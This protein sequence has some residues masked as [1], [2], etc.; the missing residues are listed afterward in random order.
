MEQQLVEYRFEEKPGAVTRSAA[1]V[2]KRA[3]EMPKNLEDC[4]GFAGRNAS[5]KKNRKHWGVQGA[6]QSQ[7]LKDLR[8][9]AG[10]T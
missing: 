1:S 2:D 9:A 7:Y 5:V 10:E 6:D 3:A 8:S 4:A